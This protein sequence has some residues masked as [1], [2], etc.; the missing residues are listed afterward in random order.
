MLQIIDAAF[1]V[2]NNSLRKGILGRGL[3]PGSFAKKADTLP[4]SF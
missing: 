4:L 2:D 3:N 1:A